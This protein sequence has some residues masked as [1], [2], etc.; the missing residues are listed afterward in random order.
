LV[1]PV[2]VAFEGKKNAVNKPQ[3]NQAPAVFVE[4]TLTTEEMLQLAS[5]YSVIKTM[6]DLIDIPSATPQNNPRFDALVNANL[7]K[8]SKL[9]E[10]KFRQLGITTIQKEPNGSLIIRIPASQ[11]YENKTPLML[12]AHM[13]IVAG[14]PENPTKPVQKKLIERDGKQFIATDGTT[15]LGSDDKG[16]IAMIVD[17]VARLLGKHPEQQTPIP[18][19]PLE[20][21]FSPDEESSCESLKT[22]DTSQFKA[23]HVLVVDEFDVFKVTTGLASAVIIDVQIEGLQGGHSGAD[24]MKPN[25]VNGIS[26]MAEVVKKLGTGVIAKHPQYQNIPLISKNIGLIQGG[27]AY[28]AIPEKAKVSIMMRSASKDAQDAELARMKAVLQEIQAKY[29]KKQ[30]TIKL[31]MTSKEEYPSW[32]G[33]VNSPLPNLAKNASQAMSGPSV[34]VGPI[35]AAAQASILANKTNAR[36][37]KFDAVLIGPHIEEAH[38]VRERIDWKSLVEARKWLEQI[39]VQYSQSNL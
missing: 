13:D 32:E 1:Q 7:D 14:D 34:K 9:V 6:F 38:T 25:R 19:A 11:G 18:H 31:V 26:L 16:G 27:S 4:R 28:N 2:F 33:D 21:L 15:T 5:Q 20:L 23:K 10:L 8:M 24:I 3:A 36:G 37:E 39:I 17:T 22:L 29:Q 30:P 35:H 12:T